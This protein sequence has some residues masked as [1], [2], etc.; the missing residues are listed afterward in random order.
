MKR[1][2]NCKINLGLHVVRR[3]ADG[4]HDLETLFLPVPLCDELE[5]EPA[6]TFSF[7]QDGLTL[8]DDGKENLVVR[9]YRQLQHLFPNR[10]R[11]VSIRLRKAIPCGAGLGGGSSDAAFTLLMLNELFG[12]HLS[13]AQLIE[14]AARLGADCPFF[15]LNQASY[16]TGI[17][18]RMTPLGFNPL[19]HRRL[20]LVKPREAVSTAEAY[21]GIVP[22]EQ[23]PDQP[24]VYLPDAV[25]KPIDLWRSEI[26]ND[27][28]TSVFKAHPKLAQIKAHLY[29]AGALYAAMSGS[30][31]TLYGIFPQ[32]ATINTDPY[33]QSYIFDL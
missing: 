28:E 2:P 12:L 5:I 32:A 1:H 20:L 27:F 8:V 31:S 7:L 15:I 13:Q 11:P 16:A 4:Y 9:A 18:D 6:D 25:R 21:R 29:A 33:E 24:Q 23:W 26:L 3:R 10:I 17:G 14:Q 19:E 22:R 30:G